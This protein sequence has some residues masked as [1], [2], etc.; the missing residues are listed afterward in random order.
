MIFINA[1]RHHICKP[2]AAAWGLQLVPN[3]ALRPHY[4]AGQTPPAVKSKNLTNTTKHPQTT[5]NDPKSLWLL[6]PFGAESLWLLNPFGQKSLWLLNPF[7]FKSLWFKSL[8]FKSL[9]V[10]YLLP[11]TTQVL[12]HERPYHIVYTF[13]HMAPPAVCYYTR[14]SHH[15]TGHSHHLAFRSADH[16]LL[17]STLAE[18]RWGLIGPR[19]V[20]L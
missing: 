11:L 19:H 15:L 3:G 2:R 14:L 7:G 9:W 17:W 6:N 18:A 20:P 12:L 13:L 8:W 1:V 5:W 10:A 4:V 16:Q